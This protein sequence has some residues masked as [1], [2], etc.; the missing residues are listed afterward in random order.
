MQKLTIKKPSDYHLHLRD[1]D[2]LQHTVM[3]TA[4]SMGS[5]VIMPNLVPPVDTVD[6]AETYYQAIK[7]TLPPNH[8]FTPLM[9][10]YLKESTTLE[11]LIA[12]AEHPHIIGCKL[13]P[14]GATTNAAQ[15]VHQLLGSA[16][17]AI[18]CGH[19]GLSTPGKRD[20]S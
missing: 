8:P 16:I 15:G 14:K 17:F 19:T 13:Y 18:G 7:A 9:T 10:L 4:A 5:A 2:V 20:L 3:A 1:G 6:R 11:T 12:A